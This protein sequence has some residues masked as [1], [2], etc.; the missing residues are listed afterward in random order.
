MIVSASTRYEY[1][2]A[3]GDWHQGVLR[4]KEDPKA[5][6]TS[7]QPSPCRITFTP[8]IKVS[9]ILPSE[10][11]ALVNQVLDVARVAL[12]AESPSTVLF[13]HDKSKTAWESLDWSQPLESNALAVKTEKLIGVMADG[14]S[15][16]PEITLYKQA[17]VVQGPTPEA[18]SLTLLSH[19][20]APLCPPHGFHSR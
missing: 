20:H 19:G 7:N 10:S 16:K 11:A 6:Y 5:D 15:K 4:S 12:T 2:D 8:S 1:M 17:A 18:S 13:D 9:R 3:E 14:C